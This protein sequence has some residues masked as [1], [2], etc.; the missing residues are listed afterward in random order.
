MQW[1]AGRVPR[2]R[3][4]GD[5]DAVAR[6]LL[7]RVIVSGSGATAVA[8][9]LTEV[10][11]Y[12]G[13]VDPASHSYRGR[14]P[15]TAVMFGPAGHLYTYFVYGM[16]WCANIVTGPDGEASAV[17][18]RAG[19]VVDGMEEARRR[20]R[21]TG[22]AEPAE[23]QLARGPAGLATVL[24]FDATSNGADLV[25]GSRARPAARGASA[26]RGR[27]SGRPQGGRGGRRRRTAAVLDRRRPD[28]LRLPRLG[29]AQPCPRRSLRC[30]AA[31]Q[32]QQEQRPMQHFLMQHFQ[33]QPSQP[34]DSRLHDTPMTGWS[35]AER[36]RRSIFNR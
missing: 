20:R 14:T 24:G 15:R 30:Q 28:R 11:A 5:V 2:E 25:A 8:V 23:H 12:A 19:Q 16:H 32:G 17:L 34:H 7:G 1:S 27:G 29:A 35:C 26:G 31:G 4:E 21:R 3:L 9:R 13:L 6:D 22:R 18:L 33:M 36:R 10:E